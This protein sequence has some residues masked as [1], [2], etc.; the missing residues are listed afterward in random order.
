MNHKDTL[1]SISKL[2]PGWFEPY[3][4][5]LRVQDVLTTSGATESYQQYS[6]C[7]KCHQVVEGR[8]RDERDLI[9]IKKEGLQGC[10]GRKRGL[11]DSNHLIVAQLTVWDSGS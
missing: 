8:I 11:L 10:Q 9:V 5:Q 4:S 1:L 2:A 3:S 7:L 6:Q